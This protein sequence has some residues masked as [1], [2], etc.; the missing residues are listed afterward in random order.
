MTRFTP[1]G[2][3]VYDNAKGADV[4]VYSGTTDEAKA[5]AAALNRLHEPTHTPDVGQVAGE[6]GLTLAQLA[7]RD[8]QV[9]ALE[10][11]RRLIGA[12]FENDEDGVQ[13]LSYQLAVDLGLGVVCKGCQTVW[14]KPDVPEDCANCDDILATLRRE[15]DD[16]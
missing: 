12:V 14:L 15:S 8:R 5:V 13:E 16:D 11:L 1:E 9:Q 10:G 3:D 2:G 6:L 4:R 7:D